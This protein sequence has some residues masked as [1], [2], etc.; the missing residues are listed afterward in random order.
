MIQFYTKKSLLTRLLK[1]L[2]LIAIAIIVKNNK[3]NSSNV[4]V[5]KNLSKFIKTLIKLAA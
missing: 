3:I 2:T 4:K 5:I 1:N